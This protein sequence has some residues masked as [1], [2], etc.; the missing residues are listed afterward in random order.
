MAVSG[1]PSTGG[2]GATRATGKGVFSGAGTST[3]VSST[4]AA[5]V[6]VAGSSVVATSTEVAV[7]AVGSATV[8]DVLAPG[9]TC[10]SAGPATPRLTVAAA[11][12]AAPAASPRRDRDRR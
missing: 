11:I 8:V 2:T 1:A 6:E 9:S 7:V 4:G 10:P 5:V 12:T 3:V